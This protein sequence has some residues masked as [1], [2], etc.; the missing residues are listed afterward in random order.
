MTSHILRTNAYK[1]VRLNGRERK[2]ELSVQQWKSA[3]GTASRQIDS[4][5]RKR[6]YWKRKEDNL[7]EE[8]KEIVKLKTGDKNCAGLKNIGDGGT[9]L[10]I[11]RIAS[12]V[13][14][15]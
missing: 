14:E 3:R 15:C 1:L 9:S 12:A 7:E 11:A 13:Q 10:H 5:T 4:G 6:Y 8:N 2:P